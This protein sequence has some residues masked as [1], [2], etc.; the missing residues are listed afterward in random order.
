MKKENKQFLLGYRNPQ[1]GLYKP[2]IN[3]K[4]QILLLAGF[5]PFFLTVGTNW[6]Y[7]IGLKLLTK[8]NPLWIYK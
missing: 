6:I 3:R 1:V 4:K 2:K 7:L 8:F 5:I